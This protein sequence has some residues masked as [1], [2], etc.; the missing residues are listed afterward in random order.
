MENKTVNLK[1]FKVKAWLSEKYQKAKTAVTGVIHWIEENP[2]AA[3]V[4]AM[5]GTQVV[6]TYRKGVIEA[7]AEKRRRRRF[8]DRRQDRWMEARRDLTKSEEEEIE[9]RYKN[10][11]SYRAILD[12]MRLLK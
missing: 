7:N 2:V 11:E 12:D 5:F 3:S 8:Y 6:R 10:G 4:I 1:E 9:I